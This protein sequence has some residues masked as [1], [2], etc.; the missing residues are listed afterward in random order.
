MDM[1]AGGAAGGT[2]SGNYLALINLFAD[3]NQVAGGV[4]I[5]SLSAIPV[6]D[7]HVIAVT[8]IIAARFADNHRPIGSR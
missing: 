2:N 3:T 8:A 4:S 6:A 1:V 7:N 5:K